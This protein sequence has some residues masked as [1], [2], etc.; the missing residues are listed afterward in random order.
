MVVTTSTVWTRTAR[1]CTRLEGSL[2]GIPLHR[3]TPWEWLVLSHVPVPLMTDMVQEACT[4]AEV[5]T[6]LGACTEVGVCTVAEEVSM[7][8]EVFTTMGSDTMRM[9]ARRA[10]VV[11][12]SLAQLTVNP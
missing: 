6:G 3:C 9:T 1:A 7:E 8:E 11:A 10:S 4:M 2:A 12:H 5:H